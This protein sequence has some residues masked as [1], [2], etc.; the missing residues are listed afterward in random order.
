MGSSFKRWIAG[1]CLAAG[2]L[3]G[4]AQAVSFSGVF[5]FG[6]SLSDVGNLQIL[7]GGAFPSGG[8]YDGGR[9]SNGPLWVEHLAFGMGFPAQASPSIT[10]GNNYAIAGART[11]LGGFPPGVLTQVGA[12]GTP[13]GTPLGAGYPM[14]DPDALYVVVAGGNNMRDARSAF[15]GSGVLDDIGRE[16]FALAAATDLANSL[17]FL[18]S[19][20]AKH[21]L[22]ANLP[23]LGDTPE[24]A[25]LG[26][27]AASTDATERFNAK[28]P[29]LI[30]LGTSFGLDVDF[31]DLES[32]SDA[33]IDDAISN[34]GAVFGITNVTLPCAGFPG[35]AGASCDVSLFSDALH[36]SAR[37]HELIGLAALR[38]VGLPEPGTVLLVVIAALALRSRRRV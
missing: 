38:A 7:T 13:G 32:L 14:A 10:G 17:G 37:A 35:S 20:G 31:L 21:V 1:A 6:D 22:I 25:F 34:G 28:V 8:P 11:G 23:D 2:S 18:A 19:R 5:I 33:V 29:G 9:F 30:A 15:P 4:T 24:A 12:W 16:A 36:P 3:I 27:Q 26:L